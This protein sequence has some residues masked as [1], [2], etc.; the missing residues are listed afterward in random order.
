M[1][2]ATSIKRLREQWL[3]FWFQPISATGFGLMRVGFGAMGLV[4]Y[5][6]Q[7]PTLSLYY[8]DQGMLLPDILSG[9]VRSQYRFSILDTFHSPLAVSILWFLLV[10]SLALVM[11]GIFT[12]VALAVSVL[13]LFSF[14]EYAPVLLDGGDTLL[15]LLGLILLVSPCHLSFSLESARLRCAAY[16]DTGKD[17][18]PR[19]RTMPVWPYRL[20]L[21]QMV[22]LYTAAFIEKMHGSMWRDGSAV[23]SVLLH[24]T[25][26]R[27]SENSALWLLPISPFLTVFTLLSQGLWMLLVIL[28]LLGWLIPSARDWLT[29]L[30]IRRAALL[31]G[32]LIHGGIAILLNLTVF[33]FIIFT[34]YAGLLLGEDFE[35][36]RKL[37]RGN[38]RSTVTVL[39]DSHCILCRRTMA[40]FSIFDWLRCLRV[41]DLHRFEDR[42]EYV[43][44]LSLE[45]LQ[46]AMHVISSDGTVTMGYD[47]FRTIA[48]YLPP[49]WPLVPLMSVPGV[50]FLGRML[51]GIVSRNRT[52]CR[53]GSCEH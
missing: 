19:S 6:L 34:S 24:P 14:H 20:L 21:W 38:K 53:D 16:V 47:G 35:A 25:F 31:C 45:S 7:W 36:L 17:L 44:H 5:A 43:P 52:T 22:C 3:H 39:Y 11:L 50:T 13:L 32:F 4:T 10:S 42:S 51:Y 28:P 33:S 40:I 2:L 46:Q 41:K 18:P 26:S 9:L 23:G 29:H 8:S 49:L 1:T 37:L 48:Q 12:R 30:P 27:L 15:R